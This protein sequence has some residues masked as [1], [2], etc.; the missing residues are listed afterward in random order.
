MPPSALR[1]GPPER[2]QATYRVVESVDYCT[3]TPRW[4]MLKTP[5][6]VDDRPES[7]RLLATRLRERLL[8]FEADFEH[9]MVFTGGEHVDVFCLRTTNPSREVELDVFGD[10]FNTNANGASFH[11]VL[12]GDVAGWIDE[13]S[14][15]VD[16]LLANDL[17]LRGRQGLFSDS[18]AQFG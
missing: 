4:H 18:R 9:E 14:R 7:Q 6:A 10:Q 15:I 1:E 12:V 17:K 11:V 16:S 5:G 13:S 2:R 3:P 8:H